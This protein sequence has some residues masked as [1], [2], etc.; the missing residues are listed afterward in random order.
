M[1]RTKSSKK[2]KRNQDE[3]ITPEF[4]ANFILSISGS[5]SEKKELINKSNV[6]GSPAAEN[7]VK[8]FA[9]F[10]R[11]DSKKFRYW[12]TPNLFILF[13]NIPNPPIPE[14][15][16][17]SHKCYSDRYVSF[18]LNPAACSNMIYFMNKVKDVLSKNEFFERILLLTENHNID[19]ILYEVISK[20]SIKDYSL[21]LDLPIAVPEISE[22]LESEYS[23]TPSKAYQLTK[24]DGELDYS[25]TVSQKPLQENSESSPSL[26]ISQ[27]SSSDSKKNPLFKTA[28][29]MKD[30]YLESTSQESVSISSSFRTSKDRRSTSVKPKKR[31]TEDANQAIKNSN[32]SSAN[33]TKTKKSN[34]STTTNSSSRTRRN[35]SVSHKNKNKNNQ[36]DNDS[37]RTYSSTGSRNKSAKNDND[38]R[39][40]YSSTGNKNS[41][42]KSSS[43]L[44]RNEE[45]SRNSRNKIIQHYSKYNYNVQE[46]E[47]YEYYEEEDQVYAD[48]LTSSTRRSMHSNKTQS[49]KS[50]NDE[51]NSKGK[52]SQRSQ[53]RS[54]QNYEEDEIDTRYS[55]DSNSKKNRI[56]RQ[57]KQNNDEAQI[58]TR[59]NMDSNSNKRKRT[60]ANNS[61]HNRNEEVITSNRNDESSSQKRRKRSSSIAT[62]KTNLDAKE[63]PLTSTQKI[64]RY[65][66][67]QSITNRNTNNT[68]DGSTNRPR[69]RNTVSFTQSPTITIDGSPTGAK[70]HAT[71]ASDH[72]R[73]NFDHNSFLSN[74]TKNTNS[75][76][77]GHLRN[78]SNTTKTL[79]KTT[80]T[81]ITQIKTEKQ[82]TNSRLSN[83]ENSSNNDSFV[84]DLSPHDETKN[85]KENDPISV[86]KIVSD[87][88]SSITKTAPDLKLKR[89]RSGTQTVRKSNSNFTGNPSQTAQM[90]RKNSWNISIDSFDKPPMAASTGSNFKYLNES[91]NP[92]DKAINSDSSYSDDDFQESVKKEIDD[93]ADVSDSID[94]ALSSNDQKE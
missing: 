39:K 70:R 16:F 71:F 36:N 12:M 6:W 54:N 94:K 38:S 86:L 30:V 24:E 47:Y 52:R 21:N 60:S 41:I 33:S 27:P 51:Y 87:G 65:R 82:Q 57:R 7:K 62:T 15:Y 75:D 26:F 28:L 50:R 4:Q 37:R 81:T 8:K 42:I 34:R 17:I 76:T 67:S 53:R 44:S 31:D 92:D 84:F 20:S 80:Q 79:R 90:L 49:I 56:N 40:T 77:N 9:F 74:S 73:Y 5:N 58:D 93:A 14:N 19:D 46:D 35:L 13:L 66:R 72:V 61:P 10:T 18:H 43:P 45:S 55:M 23:A 89:K 88:T 83:D 3:I 48:N 32:R 64:K 2:Q 85:E 29:A 69:N 59:Y 78:K 63:R 68:Y 25:T 1:K 11:G 22:E 91:T